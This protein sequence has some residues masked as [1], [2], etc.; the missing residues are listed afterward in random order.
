MYCQAFSSLPVSLF[1]L[2]WR[3]W[4]RLQYWKGVAHFNR[5]K[6]RP[7]SFVR[8]RRRILASHTSPPL[9]PPSSQ[10]LVFK[11]T[12][13]NIFSLHTRIM[14][15]TDVPL[16]EEWMSFSGTWVGPSR[17]LC[18]VYKEAWREAG[19]ASNW[20]GSVCQRENTKT[21]DTCRCFFFSDYI[22]AKARSHDN[23]F[24]LPFHADND[25]LKQKGEHSWIRLGPFTTQRQW[26]K[27]S[28]S[29]LQIMPWVLEKHWWV[30]RVLLLY[31]KSMGN[32]HVRSFHGAI[33]WR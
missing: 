12:T 31:G 18:G 16:R 27:V 26:K 8:H 7:T 4:G 23:T 32:G 13:W 33:Y 22:N 14:T 21:A 11:S 19:K 6:N 29:P 24:L 25:L 2:V 30:S 5:F 17:E 28:L 15:C 3:C 9:T 1:V 20:K 10:P